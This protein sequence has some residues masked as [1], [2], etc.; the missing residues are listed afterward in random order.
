MKD[1]RHA[2]VPRTELLI[3]GMLVEAADT[4]ADLP[5]QRGEVL[6]VDRR[7]TAKDEAPLSGMNPSKPPVLGKVPPDL[8]A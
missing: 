5:G 3:E 7:S 8:R 6:G 2:M 4:E 1:V